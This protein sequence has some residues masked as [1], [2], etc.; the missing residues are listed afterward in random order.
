MNLRQKTYDS[1]DKTN[2]LLKI[3]NSFY[4][5]RNLE[6]I[7]NRKSPYAQ[8]K[9]YDHKRQYIEPFKDY[10]VQKENKIISQKLQ[11]I[12]FK[13]VQ[14]RLN[15]YYVSRQGKISDYRKKHIEIADTL[16]DK[17]NGK[18][19]DRI[20]QQKAFIDPV[21]MDEEYEENHEKMMRKLRRLGGGENIVLPPI[22][23]GRKNPILQES[24]KHYATEGSKKE[25]SSSGDDS[26]TS[27]EKE[28]SSGDKG[29][30]GE[31]SEKKEKE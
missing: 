13:Q 27:E 7:R 21:K 24:Q 10:Y 16:R 5:S 6:L 19:R 15:D 17:E 11:N 14:P 4:H 20:N 29:G 2:K 26:A 18:Y 23:D 12:R 9:K 3:T 22:R 31:E 8:P 30:E 28:D 25:G 1:F